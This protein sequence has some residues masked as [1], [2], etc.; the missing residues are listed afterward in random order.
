MNGS[1]S[2]TTFSREGRYWVSR[3]QQRGQK[4][5]QCAK[6]APTCGLPE[7]FFIADKPL[8]NVLTKNSVEAGRFYFDHA[9]GRLYFTDN[10][11]GS[12]VEAIVGLASKKWRVFL[13]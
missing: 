2:L 1:G 9:G 4:H 5:G 7:G 10:P 3:Q 6:E 11:T 8:A 13:G 12:K